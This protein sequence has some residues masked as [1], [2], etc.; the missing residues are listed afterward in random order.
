LVGK[1]KNI[2]VRIAKYNI[3]TLVDFYQDFLSE[4]FYEE[5]ISLWAIKT[6]V[7]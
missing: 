2:L 5:E 7:E 4:K 6:L 3:Y 1:V